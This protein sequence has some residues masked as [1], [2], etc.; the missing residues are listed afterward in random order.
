MR[1]FTRFS[2][3]AA[4]L[5]LAACS[6]APVSK[7][8]TS[9]AEQEVAASPAVPDDSKLQEVAVTGSRHASRMDLPAQGIVAEG[10][11]LSASPMIAFE[12]PPVDREQYAT[13]TRTR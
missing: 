1:S 5:A 10:Y 4:L 7:E 11:V 6:P 3:A 9:S 2:A 8:E 12:A 13:S